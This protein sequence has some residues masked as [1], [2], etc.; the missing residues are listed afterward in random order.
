MTNFN[1]AAT[2]YSPARAGAVF[3]M[4]ALAWARRLP[5]PTANNGRLHGRGAGVPGT[6]EPML[7][8][9][10]WL[11]YAVPAYVLYAL[12]FRARYRF[13]PIVERFPPRDLYGVMD[14]VLF[15]ALTG[16]SAWLVLG[17]WPDAGDAVSLPAGIA[18]WTAG[19]GLRWWAI[20]AL[21]EHWRIGQ[22]RGDQRA[23]FVAAGPYRF[24]RH[25]INAAL[26]LVAA[27]MAMITG[28]NAGVCVLLGCALVYYVVQGAAENRRW[29]KG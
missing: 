23:A 20:T 25:P 15:V 19:V 27:G 28:F 12:V 22:D 9:I 10:L 29:R 26:I 8:I 2:G 11:V 16:Y 14:Q 4:L 17:R 3:A 6:L 24:L 1:R 7:A 21:G 13:S 18:L 5:A